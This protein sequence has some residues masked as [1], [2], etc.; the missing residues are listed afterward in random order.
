[1][2]DKVE[3]RKH[4]QATGSFVKKNISLKLMNKKEDSPAASPLPTEPVESI[5]QETSTDPRGTDTVEI[6][7]EDLKPAPPTEDLGNVPID[8]VGRAILAPPITI[9]LHCDK[10]ILIYGRMKK[11]KHCFC[12][13]CA[14]KG[15]GSCP[16]CKEPKQEF[17]EA[18]PRNLFICTH[19]GGRYDNKGCGNSYRSKRDLDAHVQFRHAPKAPAGQMLSI[20]QPTAPATSTAVPQFPMSHPGLQMGMNPAGMVPPQL[21]QQRLPNQPMNWP[22]PV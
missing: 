8:I 1:M 13:E 18:L 15:G 21:A 2:A 3:S 6:Q 5:P 17:E 20:P 19:G 14:K 4:K 7:P 16:L 22:N 12:R 9:C 10:P 11:C